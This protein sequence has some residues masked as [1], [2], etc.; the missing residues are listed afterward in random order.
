MEEQ[1]GFEGSVWGVAK[2]T[3]LVAVVLASAFATAW[4]SPGKGTEPLPTLDLPAYMGRWHQVALYPNRFQA[5][6]LDSTTATYSLQED[7]HVRVQ[8]RCR[9]QNGWDDAEG[10]ARP[11]EGVERRAAG[12]VAP[13]SL[14]VSFLPWYLRWLGVGW[15]KYDV[16]QLGPGQQWVVV[17]EPTQEYLWVLARTP[18][19]DTAQWAAVEA[20]LR[21]RGFDLTRLKREMVALPPH[22]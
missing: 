19:L 15:G 3:G 10:I 1:I 21:Q 8:N 22:H 17:S 6:C 20:L 7:G 16:L 2:H 11:R 13:A 4:A 5:H 14:E 18:Q 12:V 9:T